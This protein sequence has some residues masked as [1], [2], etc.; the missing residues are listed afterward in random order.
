MITKYKRT[1]EYTTMRSSVQ[2]LRIKFKP[3][4]QVLVLKE[5]DY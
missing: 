3:L 4:N 1:I 2:D 5:R